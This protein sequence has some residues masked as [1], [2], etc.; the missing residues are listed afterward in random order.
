LVSVTIK[1]GQS[2]GEPATLPVEAL[3]V[4]SD[5]QISSALDAARR[6]GA[7]FPT[8]GVAGGDL[9]RTLA[10][11]GQ[12][13]TAFPIDLGEVLVDGRHHYFAAHVVA[14]R[15]GWRDF[16]VAMNAQ[17]IGEWNLGP[18]AHPNDGIVDAYEGHLRRFEWR[19][20]RKR[21][22]TGSHLPHPRITPTRAKAVTFEFP[23]D[24]EVF[25]DGDAIA[26]A[27]HLAIRIIPDAIRVVA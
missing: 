18:K 5:R 27:R 1:P 17:W 11:T 24:Y 8:F 13:T 12:F 2:W 15:N 23:S 19:E 21:L 4:R 14:R 10:G 3:V 22:P 20:V 6:D 16:A 9:C 25:V 26:R 7:P